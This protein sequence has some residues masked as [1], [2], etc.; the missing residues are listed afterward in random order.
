MVKD[1]AMV[2]EG[3]SPETQEAPQAEMS[4]KDHVY[5]AGL[6]KLLHSKETSGN[7]VGMLKSAPPE[8]SIP[9]AA[10]TIF[11]QYDKAISSKGGDTSLETKFIGGVYIVQDL[12]EIGNASRAW[13]QEVDPEQGIPEYLQR[14]LQPFIE[15][16]LA[17][18][19]IDPV[20]LQ[21]VIEPMMNDDQVAYGMQAAEATGTP[22]IAGQQA[23]METYA[24]QRER[25]A[26]SKATD[27]QAGQNRQQ[28]LQGGA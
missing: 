5:V 12:I 6:M 9:Q 14:S 2:Q 23:A 22:M 10:M 28:M 17:D 8:K 15:K 13:E 7:I 19:S 27:K 18:G 24:S 4:Q 16:G 21:A 25:K 1:N 26:M 11:D 3:V 20:E